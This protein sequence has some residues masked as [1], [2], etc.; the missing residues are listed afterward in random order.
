MRMLTILSDNKG[1]WSRCHRTAEPQ[2][3]DRSYSS[4]ICAHITRHNL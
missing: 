1:R 2:L 4:W 3:Y